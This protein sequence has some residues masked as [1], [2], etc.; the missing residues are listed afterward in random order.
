MIR[1]R[2]VSITLI[3]MFVILS[4]MYFLFFQTVTQE[5]DSKI[6]Q[7]EVAAECQEFDRERSGY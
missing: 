5:Q 6:V 7:V 4:H 1:K 3:L 2:K